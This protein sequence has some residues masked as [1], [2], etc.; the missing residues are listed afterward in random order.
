MQCSQKRREERVEK[1]CLV[2]AELFGAKGQRTS[3]SY[4]AVR[5]WVTEDMRDWGWKRRNQAR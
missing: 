3:E 2:V 4:A 5:G 1:G